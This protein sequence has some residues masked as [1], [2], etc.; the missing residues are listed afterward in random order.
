MSTSEAAPDIDLEST[1][2]IHV[3]GVG[4]A[5]MR[6]IARVLLAMGHD[7]RG[8]DRASS[9]Y[10][11]ELDA[12]G[13]SVHV[14]HAPESL[15]TV[16]MVTRSTA[17]PDT[18]PEVMA[19]TA[20]GIPVYSRADMLAAITARRP[21]ILVAGTH[22]KTTTSSMLAVVLDHA[23]RDP[24]F[25]IGSDVARFGTGARW[26]T[27]DLFVVEA[28]ESDG[29]F[30]RLPGAHAIV[31]SLDPDHLEYYGSCLLY[32]SPSPRDATLS[33]MPSSA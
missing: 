6:A 4:G 17:V 22:G 11:E 26:S 19:A 21:G 1:R 33:R 28:D 15:T 30:L 25:V 13:A 7:V 16:D 2:S 29:T 24:S 32:T 9:V 18:D 3:V 20:A 12:L 27:S 8:S 5:G 23:G 10:L 14:G 31:T